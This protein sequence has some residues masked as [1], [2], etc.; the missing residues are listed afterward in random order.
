MAQNNLL[1]ELAGGEDGVRRLVETFYDI[2]E[3]RP[4][5]RPLLAL[6]MRGHGVAHSR[7]EQFNF[8]SGFFGG[9]Q[10]YAERHG[11]SNVRLMHEHVEIN[12]QA[13]DAWINCMAMAI[14]DVGLP[15][16]AKA[17]M[18]KPFTRVA[19]ILVNRD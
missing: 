10:L 5:G 18:M 3:T 11:H 17:K 16:D 13:R 6:H 2:V 9:P 15:P 7:I 4:E 1:Y 19:D 12:P 14:D 8:L